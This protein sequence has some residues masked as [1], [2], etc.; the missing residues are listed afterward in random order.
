MKDSFKHKGLRQKLIDSLREKGI[1]NEKVLEAMNRVP[2][3]LFMDSGFI[4]HSYTDKAFPIAAGQTI[5][6]PYTVAFQTELLDP[7]KHQ[8]ILEVGTGS[9]YQTAVLLELGTRVYTVERIKELYL[10]ARDQ[11]MPL[12]YRPGFYYGDGYEGLPAFA[13]FDRILVTAGANDI[14]KSSSNNWQLEGKWSYQ[15][16]TGRDRKCCCWKRK[17]KKRWLQLNMDTLHLFHYFRENQ[18]NSMIHLEK[19]VFNSFG[20]NTYVLHDETG[21]CIITDPANYDKEEDEKLLPI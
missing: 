11:L 19:L 8:K 5:S 18:I 20:V 10:Y 17:V 6:Q 14:P 21:E 2:R 3:H 13:P 7:R 12:G 16:V 4:N 1:K 9:G 15:W